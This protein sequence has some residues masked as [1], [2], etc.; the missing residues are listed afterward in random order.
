MINKI[1]GFSEK[2]SLEIIAYTSYAL[3]TVIKLLSTIITIIKF[4]SDQARLKCFSCPDLFK[5]FNK[6]FIGLFLISFLKTYMLVKS[7]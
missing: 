6:Y 3:D 4:G 1:S 2:N 5:H 7:R